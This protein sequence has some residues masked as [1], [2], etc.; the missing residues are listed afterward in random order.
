MAAFAPTV[1]GGICSQAGVSCK[2]P[3]PGSAQPKH[4]FGIHSKTFTET[5]YMPGIIIN[6][7][8]LY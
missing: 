8:K 6:T 1:A 7:E 3:S 4:S 2:E 5:S